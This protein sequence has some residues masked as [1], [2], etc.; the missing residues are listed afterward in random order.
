MTTTSYSPCMLF[1]WHCRQRLG[2]TVPGASP[3]RNAYVSLSQ[4]TV[5]SADRMAPGSRL[6]MNPRR[7]A[8]KSRRSPN[9]RVSAAS[10]L[11][12]RTWSDAGVFPIPLPRFLWA[13]ARAL[14][15]GPLRKG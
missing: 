15:A 4:T 10:R 13:R 12:R 14:R 7:A 1:S 8:S 3:A 11:A 2:C 9:G 5:P 6:A